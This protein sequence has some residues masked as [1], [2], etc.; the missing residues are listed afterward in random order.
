VS[1]PISPLCWRTEGAVC[2]GSFTSTAVRPLRP[3]SARAPRLKAPRCARAVTQ[4]NSGS[5]SQC[6][7]RRGEGLIDAAARHRRQLAP[8]LNVEARAALLICYRRDRRAIPRR[9]PVR[10]SDPLV[11]LG[12]AGGDRPPPSASSPPDLALKQIRPERP[13][14]VA[15][16]CGSAEWPRVGNDPPG[17]WPPL[18][19]LCQLRCGFRRILA[20]QWWPGRWRAPSTRSRVDGDTSNQTDYYLGL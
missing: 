11:R 13:I 20:G 16:G 10:G 6:H 3:T 5:G 1:S 2:A 4:P 8:K 17:T 12:P 15:S 9:H 18:L 19:A 14:S 7:D